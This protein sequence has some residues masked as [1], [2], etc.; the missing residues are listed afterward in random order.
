MAKL[1]LKKK[2]QPAWWFN[3]IV[4]MDPCASIIPGSRQQYDK[5]RQALKGKKRYVSD[6][7]KLYSRN[8]T[9]PSTVLKQ[10][11]WG[12]RKVNWLM[13]LAKGVLHVEVLPEDWKLDGEGMAEAASRLPKALR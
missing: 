9:E 3:N 5:M 11:S 2:T 1:L 6:D 10:N 13:V 4:W 12:G 7:A 8:L